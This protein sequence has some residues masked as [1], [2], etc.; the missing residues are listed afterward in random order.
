M[1]IGK[2]HV[3]GFRPNDVVASGNDPRVNVLTIAALICGILDKGHTV[4]SGS[5]IVPHI[6]RL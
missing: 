1:R 2:F 4:S 6:Y 5:S 3:T